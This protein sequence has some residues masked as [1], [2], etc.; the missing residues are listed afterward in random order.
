MEPL[1]PLGYRFKKRSFR[2]LVSM[3]DED[4]EYTLLNK[5][6]VMVYQIPP[7][8]SSAGHKAD[9]WKKCIWRGRLRMAGRGRDLTIKLLDNS[10]GNLFAQCVIPGGDH[11]SYVERVL[12]SSRYF[13]LKITNG[14][15]WGP[16]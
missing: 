5:R 7:A 4:L 8:S 2:L 9:D 10:S 11:A 1:H 13:V 14:D 16:A 6:E 15:R 12:D 3:D